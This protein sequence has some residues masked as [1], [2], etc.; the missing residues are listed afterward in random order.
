MTES[1]RWAAYAR[2]ILEKVRVNGE[3]ALDF[4]D[5]VMIALPPSSDD[6]VQ[7]DAKPRENSGDADATENHVDGGGDRG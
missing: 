3:P 5:R 1:E 7:G 2:V 4:I 6:L